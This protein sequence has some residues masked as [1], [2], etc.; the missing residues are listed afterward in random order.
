MEDKSVS[1]A[2]GP[3]PEN[4]VIVAAAGTAVIPGRGGLALAKRLEAA[5]V[6]ETEACA[7][8]GIIDPDIIRERKLAAYAA[9]KATARREADDAAEAEAERAASAD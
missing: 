4:P 2:G 8:D 1:P 9:E 5:M 7:A 3:T 6:A